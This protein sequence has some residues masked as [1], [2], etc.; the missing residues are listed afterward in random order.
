MA[1]SK[2]ESAAKKC[3]ISRENFKKN[4]KPMALSFDGAQQVA[5]ADEFS[6]GSFGWKFNEKITIMVDGVALRCQVSCNI[7]VIGSKEV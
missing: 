1:K 4:A 6:T 7:T 3:P 2:E 5:I